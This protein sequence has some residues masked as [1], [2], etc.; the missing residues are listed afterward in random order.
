MKILV[1][2]DER[3]IKRLF[4]QRFRREVKS[5][6]I[7]LYFAY[8]GQEALDFLKDGEA[9]D[10]TLLLSD[11]NM[12]NMNGL[13]LLK[14]VRENHTQLMVYM[15]TAYGDEANRKLAIELGADDYIVK[16]LDFQTLKDKLLSSF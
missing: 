9:S 16:P 6:D 2:D 1:V 8:S 10:I 13:E 5:G 4:E 12:P 7:E 14:Q 3:H 11:I 15:I